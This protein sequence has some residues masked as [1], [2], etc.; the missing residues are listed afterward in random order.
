MKTFLARLMAVLMLIAISTNISFSQSIDLDES[1]SCVVSDVQ[2]KVTYKEK[3]SSTV[4][5]VTAGTV[6]PADASVNVPKKASFSLICDDRSL[7]VSKKGTYQMAALSNDVQSKGEVSRFAKMA[8]AACAGR[9][10]AKRGLEST[11]L[12]T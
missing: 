8:F 9:T 10:G 11:Q 5:P 3:G 2:G 7:P 1:T 12:P 4:K 6:L